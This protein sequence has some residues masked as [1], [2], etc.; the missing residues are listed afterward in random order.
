MGVCLFHVYSI[1]IFS[2]Q[3]AAILPARPQGRVSFETSFDLKKFKLELKLVLALSEAKGLFLLFASMPKQRVSVF[4]LN[5]NKRKSNRNCL[6]ESIFWIFQ[7]I[8]GF[9]TVLFVSVVSI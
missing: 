2:M 3:S 6:I 1:I 8:K 7:K 5:Q 4:R 9:E